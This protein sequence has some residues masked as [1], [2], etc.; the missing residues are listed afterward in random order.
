MLTTALV[1]VLVAAM[2]VLWTYPEVV[3]MGRV[4][5]TTHAEGHT[6]VVY[7]VTGGCALVDNGMLVQIVS[8]RIC[9]E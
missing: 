8:T 9:T 2:L 5:S 3:P 7:R 4:L 6:L 1:S